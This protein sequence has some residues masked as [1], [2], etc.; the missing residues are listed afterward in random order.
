MAE[1]LLLVAL[2]ARALAAAARR[3]GRPA[4]A[5]D[6]FG[7]LDLVAAVAAHRRVPGSFEDGF[8][9]AALLAAAEA[10]AP[11]GSGAGVICG[12][13]LEAQPGLVA[14]LADGRRL[15]GSAADAVARLKDPFAFALLLARIGLPHPPV[16]AGPAPAAGWLLKR[17][18]GAGGGH[19]RAARPGEVAAPGWYLQRRVGGTP[20]SALVVGDGR[21]GRLLGWSA[22]WADGDAAQPFRWA[23]AV[24]PAAPPPA[25][26]AAVAAAL[27]GLVAESGLVGLASLDLLVEGE[28]FHLLE[29]NA[30]PGAT[31]DIFDGEGAGS[32][33]ALHLAAC[34]GRL[35]PGWSPPRTA[36]AMTV[37]YAGRPLAV[38]P[39][40][41]WPGWTADRSPDGTCFAAGDP[42]CTVLAEAAAPA[43]ARELAMSRAGAV[44]GMLESREESTAA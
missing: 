21:R 27:D 1:P 3:A 8:E 11:R 38:P 43:A 42:V 10:L 14:A 2:S 41:A 26:V 20:V 24:Q 13:G 37:V 36:R 18:G 25:V 16:T 22:Q 7:D 44:L 4:V 28:A 29:V 9:P 31:L 12:A 17:A 35:A 40:M 30:R 19:V 15:L 33:L 5:L 34:D 23:G 39:C 6:L 32:L